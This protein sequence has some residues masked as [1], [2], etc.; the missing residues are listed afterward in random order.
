M[1]IEYL[2]NEELLDYFQKGTAENLFSEFV[3]RTSPEKESLAIIH[4]NKIVA[5][6]VC[7]LP[8]GIF[9]VSSYW[10]VSDHEKYILELLNFFLEKKMKISLNFHWKYSNIIMNNYKNIQVSK[11]LYFSLEKA[12]FIK[13]VKTNNI[14]IPLDR[15]IL[16]KLSIMEDVAKRIGPF[17]D[18]L[19]STPFWGIMANNTLVGITDAI[20]SNERYQ[21]IQQVFVSK[22]HRNKGYGTQLVSYVSQKIF[23]YGKKPTYLVSENSP[24][25]ISLVSKLGFSVIEKFGYVD[26]SEIYKLNNCLIL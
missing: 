23:N 24:Q 4:L 14:I 9:A 16:Q 8:F 20:V 13:P 7:G 15:E 1:N 10:L 5:H 6:A 11:D 17:S 22:E 26:L 3:I 19:P 18:F 12:N 2:K 25:S 21:T